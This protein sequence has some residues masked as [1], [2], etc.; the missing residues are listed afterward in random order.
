MSPV[1]SVAPVTL[2]A[3]DRGPDLQLRVSVP[4]GDDPVPVLLFAHGFGSS[5]RAYGPLTDHWAANGFAVIQPTFLDSRTV[6]LAPD[7]P[8]RPQLWRHRVRD[9]IRILDGLDT[10]EAAAPALHGRLDRD[11]VVAAGHSF[12]GQTAGMLLGLQVRDPAT[13]DVTDLSDDRVRAAVLLATAGRGGD[14]LAPGVIEQ[15]PWLNA[16]F[17]AMAGPALVVMGD[18]DANPLTTRGPQ[19]SADPYRLSPLGKSLLTLYG[20]EHSLGGIPGYEAA[21]TTDE[22]PARVAALQQLSTAYLRTALDP[23]DLAWSEA[24][25][26]FEG[27]PLGRIE[28]R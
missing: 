27:S 9:M 13:G 6:G 10:V 19:W 5:L 28:S 4:V 21:E 16:E 23:A 8:R 7:D 18:A 12:G 17:S 26:A 11:R 3:P 22:N 20:A 14:S 1:L 15:L 25:V 24:S 2:P